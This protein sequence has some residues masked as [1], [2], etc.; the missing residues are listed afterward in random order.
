M[1]QG[2]LLILFFLIGGA[3]H[4]QSSTDYANRIIMEEGYS[5]TIYKDSLGNRTVGYGHKLLPFE[6]FK[7]PISIQTA[8]NLLAKDLN[9][10][11]EIAKRQIPSFNSQPRKVKIILVSMAF[12]LGERGLSRFTKFKSQIKARNYDAAAKELRNSFYYNQLPTRVG[13]YIKELQ[14]IP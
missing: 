10:A 5:G 6:S 8:N 14:N 13:R 9:S 3:A 4:A 1:R 12:N 11:I 7:C 2:F